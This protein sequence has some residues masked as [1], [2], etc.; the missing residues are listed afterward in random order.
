MES[1]KGGL[2][3]TIYSIF[4]DEMEHVYNILKDISVT[5]PWVNLMEENLSTDL[6]FTKGENS[7]EVGNEFYCL[8]K[9][10]LRVYFRVVEMS[11]SEDSAICRWHV[12]K[13]DPVDIPY[14]FSYYFQRNTED[15]ST[16]LQV[17]SLF[18]NREFNMSRQDIEMIQEERKTMYQILEKCVFQCE[19]INLQNESIGIKTNIMN[20]SRILLNFKL[21]HKMVPIICERVD[22]KG[23]EVDEDTNIKFHWEGRV[24]M[25]IDIKIKKILRDDTRTLIIYE[26][27]DGRQHVPA[28]QVEW[29]VIRVDEENSFINFRHN[30]TEKI[31]KKMLDS[32]SREKKLILQ[33]LK[34][35]VEN[36]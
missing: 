14:F 16:V 18:C 4:R 1:K 29:E 7:Y 6:T 21:F 2:R 19:K 34:K 33:N 28:Q 25:S 8:W 20:I 23:E 12:Y 22:Y 35:A 10:I 5:S 26:C 9:K 15:N 11:I 31:N 30:F 17:E 24:K 27:S 32:I 3:I 13:S 36:S